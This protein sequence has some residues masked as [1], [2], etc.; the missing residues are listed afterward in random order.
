MTTREEMVSYIKARKPNWNGLRVKGIVGR[1][2]PFDSVPDNIIRGVYFSLIRR[3]RTGSR[4]KQLEL[5][6]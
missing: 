1:T 3:V 5:P 2:V 6:L 4:A